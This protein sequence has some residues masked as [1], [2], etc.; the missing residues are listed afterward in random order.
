MS[1]APNLPVQLL[2]HSGTGGPLLHAGSLAPISPLPCTLVPLSLAP[3]GTPSLCTVHSVAFQ[4]NTGCM[5]SPLPRCL[6][7]LNKLYSTGK[8]MQTF[9]IPAPPKLTCTLIT[10]INASGEYPAAGRAL[11]QGGWKE[12]SEGLQELCGM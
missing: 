12:L 3:T 1:R 6:S 9:Q 5:G 11:D 2:C 10:L 4:G 8:K 7:A